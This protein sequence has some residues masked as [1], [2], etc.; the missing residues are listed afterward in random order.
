MKKLFLL[1]LILVLSSCGQNNVTDIKTTV[2]SSIEKTEVLTEKVIDKNAE[3][4]A[5]LERL[6]NEEKISF[7]KM[8]NETGL[9]LWIDEANY[10]MENQGNGGVSI[11]KIID[12]FVEFGVSYGDFGGH[13]EVYALEN[14]EL[15]QIWSG[16]EYPVSRQYCEPYLRMGVSRGFNFMRNCDKNLDVK[17]SSL[18][19]NLKKE[20][21]LTR[22]EFVDLIGVGADEGIKSVRVID[23]FG[24][25]DEYISFGV[26]YE[27]GG[28]VW[29]YERKDGIYKFLFGTQEALSPKQCAVWSREGIGKFLCENK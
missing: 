25:N 14:G 2:G 21:E 20:Q 3:L 26:G 12:N 18:H 19:E 7:S 13:T 10:L 16:Q 22:D 6:K 29:F 4:R 1:A 17:V 23:I 8:Q 27:Y 24:N 11:G 9:I 5:K 28:H 15:V